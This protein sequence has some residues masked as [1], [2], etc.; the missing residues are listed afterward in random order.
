MQT[1]PSAAAEAGFAAMERPEIQDANAVLG[2]EVAY[3]QEGQRIPEQPAPKPMQGTGQE[4]E[5]GRVA[6]QREKV[7]ATPA[8]RRVQEIKDNPPQ[9]PP[10][11]A[12]EAGMKELEPTPEAE[13]QPAEESRVGLPWKP[14]LTES[15][16]GSR[17][18][19]WNYRSRKPWGPR[20]AKGK[21][22]AEY[23]ASLEAPPE[24]EAPA[25]TPTTTEPKLE[26][27]PGNPNV[28][29]NAP[30]DVESAT[31][32][33]KGRQAKRESIPQQQQTLFDTPAPS[34]PKL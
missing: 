33:A 26:D 32:R 29:P 28:K 27:L 4:K 16:M 5:T 6:P 13:A 20:S 19:D 12:V 22:A 18:E 34:E 23:Y 24:A 7:P 30:T 21:A 9:Q 15:G 11:T 31:Q 2:G 10:Q 8:S 14:T 25:P 17:D 3:N 1:P